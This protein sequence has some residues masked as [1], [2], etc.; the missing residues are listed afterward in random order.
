MFV[1]G[2]NNG[3]GACGSHWN[4]GG[5]DI[6]DSNAGGANDDDDDV[7]A[8]GPNNKLSSKAGGGGSSVV[9]GAGGANIIPDGAGCGGSVHHG[10]HFHIGFNALIGE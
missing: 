3:A 10:F 1:G 5:A 9:S 7:V 6:V 2:A 8:G 4:V